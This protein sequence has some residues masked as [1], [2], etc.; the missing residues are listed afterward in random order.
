MLILEKVRKFVIVKLNS[1]IQFNN[2]KKITVSK[3]EYMVADNILYI[4]DNILYIYIY[5]PSCKEAEVTQKKSNYK[6]KAI[7][8]MA[9]RF[10]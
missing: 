10:C 3:N 4:Y 1:T 7:H 5:K 6:R 9:K 2:L 8:F